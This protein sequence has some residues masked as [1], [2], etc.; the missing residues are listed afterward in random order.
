[1]SVLEE[2]NI[3]KEYAR[4]KM[5][6]DLNPKSNYKVETLHHDS[7]CAF[8]RGRVSSGSEVLIQR[9]SGKVKRV[10]CKSCVENLLRLYKAAVELENISY[11]DDLEEIQKTNNIIEAVKWYINPVKEV[12]E[13]EYATKDKEHEETYDNDDN[14]IVIPFNSLYKLKRGISQCR[15]RIWSRTDCCF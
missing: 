6:L 9:E 1:M 3:S 5:S 15:R 14:G 2:I 7:C 11:D 12:G 4:Y 10:L 8:C 13:Y